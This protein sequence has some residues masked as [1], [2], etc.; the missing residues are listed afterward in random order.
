MPKLAQKEEKKARPPVV[1][2]LGHIDHGKSTLIDYIRKTN[3]TATEA[4]GITQ[5]ISAYEITHASKDGRSKRITFLDTPGHEAFTSIRTRCT[6]IADIAAL[7]VSAEDGVK[8]QTLEIIKYIKECDMPILV[9]ITKIDKP[10]ADVL[11]TKQNLAENDVYVEGYGGD[12]PVVEVSGK[13]GA[14]VDEFLDM[15]CLM[16]EMREGTADSEALGSG[17]IIETHRDAKRGITAV[18]IIKDGT[19]RQGLVAAAKAGQAASGG[20][21]AP[22]RFLLDGEGNMVE[23]LSFSSPVQIV[24]WDKLTE[25]G[26]EFKTFL[27]KKEAQEFAGVGKSDAIENKI[28]QKSGEDMNTLPIVVKADTAGSLEAIT[29]ELKKLSRERI[30]PKIILSGIGGV[31]END[32]KSALSATGALIFSFNTKID[33]Q[34]GFLAERLGVKILSFNVIYEFTDKVKELLSEREPKIEIEEIA[35]TSKVLKM[36][37]T[38]KDKQVIGARVLSGLVKRGA[39][40]KIIRRESEIGQGKVKELQQSKVATDSLGEGTEFGAM[41]ESKIEIV[42]G[43]MLNTVVLVTK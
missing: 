33:P 25:I 11:R 9:V 39:T 19:V 23:E 17:V 3:V 16:S 6:N 41:I 8:P 14:G 43:D 15:I 32:V 21:I 12:I 4:G 31:S 42:P 30:E 28:E 24:G 1:A 2:I 40:V 13:T 5:H 29:E 36:F 10:S 27:K 18:G 34:V 22:I 35:S 26:R 7:I 37:G 38:T 20:A